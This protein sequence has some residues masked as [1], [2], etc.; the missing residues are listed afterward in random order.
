MN[1]YWNRV[2]DRRI[3]RRRALAATGATAM[4]AAFLAACGGGGDGDGD[5]GVTPGGGDPGASGNVIFGKNAWRL[6]DET[7]SALPGGVYKGKMDGEHAG[8]FDPLS[9]LAPSE[10]P[11]G[12]HIYEALMAKNAT[13]GVDPQSVEGGTARGGLAESMEVSPDGLTVTFTLRQGV[14]F[15]NIAPVSGRVMDMDDWKTSQERFLE[16]GSL[17]VPL[18]T[19]LDKTTYPDATHMVWHLKEIYAPLNALVWSERGQAFPIMPKE[20][21]EDTALAESTPIGTGFKI[22]DDLQP[23]NIIKFKKNPEYWGGNPFIDAWNGPIIPEYANAYAQFVSKNI[24]V[25]LTT[26]R[27]VLQMLQDSP[28]AQVVANDIP[29]AHISRIR[30]GRENQHDLPWEDK[31]VRQAIRQS[32]DFQ[33]I[34][35]FI[36]NSEKFESAGLEVD[37]VPR[38]HLPNDPSYWLDPRKGEYGGGLDKNFLYDVADARAKIEAAG[39]SAPIPIDYHAQFQS[40]GDQT[41]EELLIIDSFKASGNFDPTVT[42]YNNR[43][44]QRNCRS[45]GQC[46]GIVQSSSTRE[47]DSVIFRD[48]HSEGN[49]SGD[50]AYPHAEI[51]RL[52]LGQRQ[53]KTVAERIGFLQEFLR[54]NADFMALL[55]YS[56]QFTTFVFRH[57]WVHNLGHGQPWATAAATTIPEGQPNLGGHLQWLDADMPGRN[58]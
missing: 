9:S 55:P 21:N 53:A 54:F 31:R 23:G 56:D 2:L 58:G 26:P 25:M 11:S 40:S 35:R 17:K 27:D 19:I 15:Q 16:F 28:D 10:V 30:F 22:L 48:Y 33:S 42:R 13:P 18:Q 37:Q 6:A 45:L 50:Q 24:T 44:Q 47:A 52:A 51:D 5:S 49:T 46:D 43:T 20:L 41:D 4:G 57:P 1:S 39:F 8:H 36:S 12:G 3:T 34:G 32:I 7:S 29:V 38:T 14:K